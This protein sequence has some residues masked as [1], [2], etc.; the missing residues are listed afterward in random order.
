[1]A[2]DQYSVWNT[3]SNG[4]YINNAIGVV[5]G[6]SETMKSFESIFLQDFSGDGVIGA[7]VSGTVIE[8]AGSTSLVQVGANFYLNS[9]S[10][11]SG[12]LLKQ[13][14]S[15]FVAGQAGSWLPIAVEQTATGY[16]VAWKNMAADQYSVWNTDSNGNYINNAIGVVSGASTTLKSYETSFQQDLNSDGV[17]GNPTSAGPI[18]SAPLMAEWGAV[19]A[20]FNFA[21]LLQTKGELWTD[22]TGGALNWESIEHLNDALSA[23]L[24][25]IVDSVGF[26]DARSGASDA[27]SFANAALVDQVG[28]FIIH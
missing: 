22:T 8:S 24:R 1:M 10:A 21:P 25:S 6:A 12:P 9:I 5:S 26:D 23:A 2:A 14:G 16:Q 7:P 15:A 18:S 28:H 13:G 19:N 20:G 3:D 27:T 17:I 4:N 11:G